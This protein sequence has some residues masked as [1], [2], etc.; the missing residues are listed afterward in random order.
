M[1]RKI[2]LRG[3]AKNRASRRAKEESMNYFKEFLKVIKHFFPK[4]L[5]WLEQVKDPRHQSY[6]EYS[7]S[8]VLLIRLFGAS[9]GIKSM[10][11]ITEKFNNSVCIE[12]MKRL[13]K[14]KSIIEL[15]HYDTIND[16]LEVLEPD[17]MKTL[18]H[19]LIVRLIQM[20]CFNSYKCGESWLIG[21]DGTKLYVFKER[22]CDHCLTKVYNKG[23][24]DEYTLYFHYVLE[25][26]LII[27]DM[28]FSICS[29]FIENSQNLE[30]LAYRQDFDEKAKQDCE[31]KAFYR[32]EKKLKKEYPRLPICL[33]LDSLYANQNVFQICKA[34][35]WKYII[36]F[37]DGSIPD[38]AREFEALSLYDGTVTTVKSVNSLCTYRYVNEIEHAGHKINVVELREAVDFPAKGTTETKTFTFITSPGQQIT[39]QNQEEI[40]SAGR[41]RWKIENQGFNEQKNHGY[42]LTHPFSHHHIAMKNHYFLIQI[43]HIIRQLYEVGVKVLKEF[44]KSLKNISD[45]LLED[46]RTK[47]LLP[48]DFD[49]IGTAHQIRIN[50]VLQ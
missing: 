35:A 2:S 9:M 31:L 40:V 30:E 50:N 1:K 45:A 7:M 21:I 25:A 47:I 32:M 6:I 5:Q 24:P 38:V 28:A 48:S 17:E 23:K 14:D 39:K 12:N 27:D 11:N 26:K 13:L 10:R 37:K 46:F 44:K 29:E 41:K 19:M 34:N 3:K 20:K 8:M 42:E 43:A 49:D 36:R 33:L 4:M 22:H 15:P 18:R 16:L